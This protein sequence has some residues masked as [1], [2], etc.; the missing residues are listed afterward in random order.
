MLGNGHNRAE[1]QRCFIGKSSPIYEGGKAAE[2]GVSARFRRAKVPLWSH[3]HVQS[4]ALAGLRRYPE[5]C[6]QF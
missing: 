4:A 3:W 5:K 6:E 2:N 1:A